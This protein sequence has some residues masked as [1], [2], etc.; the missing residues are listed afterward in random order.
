MGP[1]MEEDLAEMVTGYADGFERALVATG[2]S[3]EDLKDRLLDD[4]VEQ[5][6]CCRWWVDSF[7]LLNDDDAIDGHCDNCRE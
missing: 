1:K 7:Q 3:R 6:P 5:C 4:N 2:M